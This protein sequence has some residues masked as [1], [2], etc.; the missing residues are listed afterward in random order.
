[1]DGN[2]NQMQAERIGRCCMVL[3]EVICYMIG[4]PI[5]NIIYNVELKAYKIDLMILVVSGGLSALSVILCIN[6]NA[7]TKVVSGSIYCSVLMWLT[8]FGMLVEKYL[9]H[10]AAISSI[11]V[12]SLQTC[13][14]FAML[15]IAW[16]I[17]AKGKQKN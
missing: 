3:V 11:L 14:L 12:M 13:I 5:L 8:I 16:S 10:G 2:G 7:G 17:K 1:M 9:I 6:Y 15:L 4:I